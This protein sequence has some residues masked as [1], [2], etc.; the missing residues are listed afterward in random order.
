ME[1]KIII[2]FNKKQDYLQFI[3]GHTYLKLYKKDPMFGD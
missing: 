2:T 3:K 1:R